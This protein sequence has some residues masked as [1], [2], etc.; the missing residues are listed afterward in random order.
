MPA[1]TVHARVESITVP[2]FLWD[3]LAIFVGLAR[4]LACNGSRPPPYIDEEVW[5]IESH[6]RSNQ[7]YL[8]FY[9]MY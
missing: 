4:E 1:R 2:R 9:L 5:P 6:N 3:L 8:S 7:F